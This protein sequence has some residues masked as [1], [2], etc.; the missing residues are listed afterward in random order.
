[1]CLATG[2]VW[3]EAHTCPPFPQPGG[4]ACLLALLPR[5]GVGVMALPRLGSQTSCSR[6]TC[7]GIS[8]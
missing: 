3:A 7:Q 1:M 6:R 8:Q 4:K 2:E 5:G